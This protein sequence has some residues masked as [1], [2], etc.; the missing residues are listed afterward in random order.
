MNNA[1]HAKVLSAYL[2]RLTQSLIE[3]VVKEAV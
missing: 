2:S 1:Q 3:Q